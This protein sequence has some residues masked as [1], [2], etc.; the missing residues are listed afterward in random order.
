MFLHEN[1]NLAGSE[2]KE[3]KRKRGKEEK[4][5]RAKGYSQRFA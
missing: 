3:E 5:K 2:G 1:V 4:R